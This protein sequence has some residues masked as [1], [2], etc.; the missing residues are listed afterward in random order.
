MKFS[1]WFNFLAWTTDSWQENSFTSRHSDRKPMTEFFS[2]L[3]FCGC[4]SSPA[5][6]PSVY[7]CVVTFQHPSLV[8]AVSN[9]W[10]KIS[11]VVEV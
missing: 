3:H 10:G 7:A 5:K 9:R 11:E 1:T 2:Y 8:N 4:S 6:L